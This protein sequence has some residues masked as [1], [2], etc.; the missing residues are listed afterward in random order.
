[1]VQASKRL[2]KRELGASKVATNWLVARPFGGSTDQRDTARSIFFEII[3]KA[4]ERVPKKGITPAPQS[5]A[6]LPAFRTP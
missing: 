6:R 3:F 2:E 4:N 5:L 1:L